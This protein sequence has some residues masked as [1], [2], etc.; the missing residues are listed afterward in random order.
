MYYLLFI[1]NYKEREK[2]EGGRAEAGETGEFLK[3]MTQNE[4]S[5]F[6]SKIK[7]VL[8]SYKPEE[9]KEFSLSSLSSPLRD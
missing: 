2:R 6:F 4:N 9:F 8:K 5:Y 3:K 1:E 7:K